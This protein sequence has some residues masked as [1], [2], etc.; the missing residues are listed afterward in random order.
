MTRAFTTAGRLGLAL[1]AGVTL[2]L[3]VGTGAASAA[4]PY[5]YAIPPAPGDYGPP[6][7]GGDD[8]YPSYDYSRTYAWPRWGPYGYASVPSWAADPNQARYRC[9]PYG[10]GCYAQSPYAYGRGAYRGYYGNGYGGGGYGA[11][12]GYGLAYGAA[13]AGGYARSA[14]YDA[15]YSGYGYAPSQGYPSGYGR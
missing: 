4:D 9:D 8:G 3:V 6:V 13:A 5:G 14:G 12:N 7:Y 1:A 2:A 11:G 10:R 15:Y